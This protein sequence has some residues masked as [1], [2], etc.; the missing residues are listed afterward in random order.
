MKANWL[1]QL[2]LR[3]ESSR[4]QPNMI[5]RQKELNSNCWDKSFKTNPFHKN[6]ESACQPI[7]GKVNQP[8]NQQNR[9]YN[10]YQSIKPPTR[11]LTV[12]CSW[13]NYSHLLSTHLSCIEQPNVHS[14]NHL[15]ICPTIGPFTGPFINSPAHSSIHRPCHERGSSWSQGWCCWAFAQCAW[16]RTWS[17]SRSSP[18]K[19]QSPP[20]TGTWHCLVA[21][22]IEKRKKLNRISITL[23][24]TGSS[25]TTSLRQPG[26]CLRGRSPTSSPTKSSSSS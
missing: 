9:F 21:M 25:G 2:F 11:T 22:E 15:S 20:W 1:V 26:R 18:W 8:I 6:L 5:G 17:K 4:I 14:S 7:D 12:H 3:L 13:K 16:C 19:G 10:N 24:S 23:W